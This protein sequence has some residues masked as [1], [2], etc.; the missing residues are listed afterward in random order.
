VSW[1]SFANSLQ[2]QVEPP[3]GA[4]RREVI[5]G[6]RPFPNHVPRPDAVPA[7]VDPTHNFIN[8]DARVGLQ[9]YVFVTHSG[10]EFA[11]PE[12]TASVWYFIEYLYPYVPGPGE[13]APAGGY[14]SVQTVLRHPAFEIEL[15]HFPGR[16][17]EQMRINDLKF[18]LASL[19]PKTWTHVA[20]TRTPTET[21]FYYDGVLRGTGPSRPL[22]TALT[23]ADGVW[24]GPTLYGSVDEFRFYN[25]ALDAA[26]IV[27]ITK[28][29]PSLT[30]PAPPPAPKPGPVLK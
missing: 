23:S 8:V 9:S 22:P 21:K 16:S 2:D 26:A 15:L 1:F 28:A 19:R 4:A 3:A 30:T 12:L 20:V 14:A 18:D 11:I 27:A 6:A 17:S 13:S 29:G 25:Y 7:V 10:Q 5:I 24:L